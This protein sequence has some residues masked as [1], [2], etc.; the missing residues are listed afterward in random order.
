MSLLK[1]LSKFIEY[2][3][4]YTKRDNSTFF[5]TI[6]VVQQWVILLQAFLIHVGENNVTLI[7]WNDLRSRSLK[8]YEVISNLFHQIWPSDVTV[9]S[10]KCQGLVI[11]SKTDVLTHVDWQT[12][13]DSNLPH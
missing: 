13:G 12:S 9:F 6:R 2:D 10:S 3:K 11:K 5:N 4:S 7:Q 8:Q 1:Y